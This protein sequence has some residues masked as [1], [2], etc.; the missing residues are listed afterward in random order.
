MLEYP[1]SGERFRGRDTWVAINEEYPAA[2]R[3]H[4]TVDRI[5]AGEQG[6][7]SDVSARSVS[8]FELRDG[9]IRRRVEYWPDPFEAPA[10]RA[11]LVQRLGAVGGIGAIDREG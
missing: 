11:R 8:F 4:F 10:W 7:V 9:R 2:G 3:W 6:V 5:V 1:Q